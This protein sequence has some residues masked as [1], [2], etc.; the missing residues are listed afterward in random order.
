MSFTVP[1]PQIQS[2]LSMMLSFVVHRPNTLG[3]LITVLCGILWFVKLFLT[4][5]FT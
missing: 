5:I 4:D 3:L 1:V 2:P